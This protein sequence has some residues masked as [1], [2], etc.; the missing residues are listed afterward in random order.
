MYFGISN[1]Y[2]IK[3]LKPNGKKTVL[4]G[5]LSE[6]EYGNSDIILPSSDG[7][8]EFLKLNIKDNNIFDLNNAEILNDFV[9]E[10]DFDE[11]ITFCALGLSRS[12][13]VMI[14]V[15]KILQS[16]EMEEL[17]KKY[18]KFYNKY[19]VNSFEDFAYKTKNVDNTDLIFRDAYTNNT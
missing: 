16:K 17:V 3:N 4:I 6:C 8:I 11:V 18:Y 19:I 15:S 13:A 14:C 1:S 12:P 5:C 2:M 7:D 10:H 9:L